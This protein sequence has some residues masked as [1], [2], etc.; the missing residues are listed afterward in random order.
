RN[1]GIAGIRDGSGFDFGTLYD[2]LTAP[3]YQYQLS[4]DAAYYIPLAARLVRK[5][6]SAGGWISGRRLF[7]NELFQIGGFRLL[8]GFDE[9]SLFVN[10]YHILTTELRFI[11]GRASNVYL[12]ADNAWLESR[13]NGEGSEGIYNG[14]GAGA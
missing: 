5:H 9:G 14:F 3:A 4:G 8:R 11:L 13:I 1:V 7:R 12:F 2:T 6:A 10:Q